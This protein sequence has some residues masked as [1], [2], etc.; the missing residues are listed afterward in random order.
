VKSVCPK[1]LRF[2]RVFENAVEDTNA[3]LEQSYLQLA[4]Q[5]RIQLV[6]FGPRLRT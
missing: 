6:G 3:A 5:E 4:V 2:P 1:P